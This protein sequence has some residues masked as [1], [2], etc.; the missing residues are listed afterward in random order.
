M[1]LFYKLKPYQ[2]KKGQISALLILSVLYFQ[3]FFHHW[4]YIFWQSICWYRAGVSLGYQ[5]NQGKNTQFK[6]VVKIVPYKRCRLFHPGTAKSFNVLDILTQMYSRLTTSYFFIFD[7]KQHPKMLR[8]I[9][10]KI[11]PD[12]FP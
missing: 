11:T 1:H 3:N 2:N 7:G 8:F 12:F 10:V 9:D 4:F 5:P 6:P